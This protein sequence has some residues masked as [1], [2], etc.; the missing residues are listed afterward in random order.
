[1]KNLTQFY[2]SLSLFNFYFMNAEIAMRIEEDLDWS[3]ERTV[4]HF[5]MY[6]NYSGV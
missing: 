1:M 2:Y 5:A 4:D 3:E 6:C